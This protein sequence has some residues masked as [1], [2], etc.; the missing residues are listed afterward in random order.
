M[1][2][3]ILVL[4][5]GCGEGDKPTVHGDADAGV[6]G[7]LDASVEATAPD[8]PEPPVLTPCPAGWREVADDDDP[9][10][11]TCDPWPAA[12]PDECADD[13]AHFPGSPG[14]ARLGTACPAGAF[15]DDLPAGNVVHV[16]PS[17]AAGGNG[18]F[19]APYRSIAEGVAAAP[20]GAV[21]ALAKGTHAG[22]VEI[23]RGLTLWG[24]CVA[25]TTIV[26]VAGAAAV[27][28]G[29][30]ATIRNLRVA[31]GS[32]GLR[33]DGAATASSLRV[34]GA[35][36]IDVQVTTGASLVATEVVIAE[37]EGYGMDVAGEASVSRLVVLHV[38]GS[39]IRI[40]GGTIDARQV[41]V[42]ATRALSAGGVGWG[43]EAFGA[44]RAL[45]QQCAIEET[46]GAGVF[47]S[48][49]DT[50]VTLRDS[51][52]RGTLWQDGGFP[53]GVSGMGIDARSGVSVALERVWIHGNKQDGIRTIEGSG[54][55]AT[56][57]VVSDTETE[58]FFGTEGYGIA[59]ATGA[60][61]ESL[62][63]AVLRNR[64]AGIVVA[65]EGSALRGSDLRVVS[66]GPSQRGGT[67][68]DDGYGIQIY[69]RGSVDLERLVALRNRRAGIA[70][71]D[72]SGTLR[73]LAVEGT[74]ERACARD[75][76]AGE[77]GGTGVASLDGA[78][79]DVQVFRSVGNALCGVHVA[80]DG[81]L[82]LRDGEV[83]GNVV[84]A[85]VQIE[86]YDLDRLRDGVIYRDNV[87]ELDSASLPV[88]EPIGG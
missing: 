46:V 77:G 25:E 39:G 67:S 31:G 71:F 11:R 62:R 68:F 15:A 51:L 54:V 4:L 50:S 34:E 61:V 52:V 76:C 13:E 57:V 64:G 35:S 78:S 81:Q 12:G 33:A 23:R 44:T 32:I 28:V 60:A 83:S 48:G 85:N 2:T 41:A 9:E 79:V 74:L 19:A 43:I 69:H 75:E 84:G 82:D 14:C 7:G 40:P 6:D 30:G 18:S 88:P 5:A 70:V 37:S 56:D 53:S 66:T 59:V 55:T 38:R 22:G 17:A 24:A 26:G 3:G 45:L 36:E 49:A 27:P 86:G 10:V 65:D 8:P 47:A 29:G 63:V 73:H 21:V 87:R 1:G 20:D 72:A 16:D 42:R 80:R 58:T